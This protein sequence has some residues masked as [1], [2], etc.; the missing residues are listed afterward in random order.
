MQKTSFTILLLTILSCSTNQNKAE[1]NDVDADSRNFPIRPLIIESE[2]EGWGG[3]IKL[4]YTKT[5][6]TDNTV[7]YE[8]NSTYKSKEI[9]FEVSVPKGSGKLTIKRMG[10][11]SDNFLHVL[12]DI[13]KQKMDTASKFVDFIT[14][15]CMNMGDYVDSLNKQSDGNYVTTAQYKLFF[16]GKDEDDYAE[17][18]LDVNETNH[19]IELKEKDEE[20][21]PAIIKLLTR[22]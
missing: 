1:T 22:K 11:G 13:Y 2:D 12:A 17:L 7:S 4:S 14:I 18:F 3:D 6:T 16:Q 21:R 10:L 20:Y 19:L 15:D 9:G 8:V 5:L